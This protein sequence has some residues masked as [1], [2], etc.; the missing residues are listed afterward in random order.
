MQRRNK[1]LIT[2]VALLCFGSVFAQDRIGSPYTRYGVGDLLSRNF[3][4]SKAMGGTS[5]A[6]N[7]GNKLYV[8]NPASY[9]AIDSLRFVMEVGLTSAFKSMQTSSNQA[10]LSDINLDYLSFGFPVTK[11]WGASVGLLPYSNVGY[12]LMMTETYQGID[13]SY[14]YQGAGGLNQVYIG[15]SFNPFDGLSLGVNMNYMFGSIHR[16]NAVEFPSDVSGMINMTEKNSTYF[17]DVYFSVGMQYELH[18]KEDHDLNIGLVWEN[19]S[20]LNAKRDLFVTNALSTLTSSP[21]DTLFYNGTEEGTVS[22]PMCIGG[23]LAYYYSDKLILAADYY[24]QDWSDAES[25]GETDS[26]GVSQRVSFGMEW[27]PEGRMSPGLDY[28]KKV[29]YRAG[30]FYNNTYLNFNNGE[31]QINDFGISFGLGLP[32][33]RSNTTFNLSLELGQRGSLE[34]SLVREQYVVFGMNFTL[35]DIWFIKRKFD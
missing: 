26:L 20:N 31:T 21:V 10:V 32:V 4:D 6:L 15:S 9:A 23:G 30:A 3:G 16:T 14:H 33:K 22:L 25:F 12:D 5:L 8:A 13:A 34:N 29:R 11:W 19:G 7:S 27:T 18:L 24:L 28:W 35:S 2:F 1:I 17:S